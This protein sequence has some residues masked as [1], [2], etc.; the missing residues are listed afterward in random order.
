M[1]S[2]FSRHQCFQSDIYVGDYTQY[3][4]EG[5][6]NPFDRGVVI[7][8]Q[9]LPQIDSLCFKNP[10]HV[11]TCAVNFEQ[12][13][14]FFKPDGVNKVR[15][16]EGVLVSEEGSAK[17]WLAL[18]ELKY[19]KGEDTNIIANFNDALDEIKKTFL[20]LRDHKQL[21]AT[22]SFRFYWVISIPAHSEKIPF[23]AFALTQDDLTEIKNKYGVSLI[24]DNIVT[25]WTGSILLMPRY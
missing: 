19:C 20:Y 5:G 8:D 16:C 15:N 24:S 11:Q 14:A 2:T 13:S 12:Y 4:Q 25:I 18:V 17:R 7:A 9:P 21:F 6:K 10:N 3:V 23:S 22:Q 1:K